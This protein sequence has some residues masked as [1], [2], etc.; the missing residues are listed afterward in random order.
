MFKSSAV[1][2]PGQWAVRLI[3][4]EARAYLRFADT[5]PRVPGF[6]LVNPRA[7][8]R[9]PTAEDLVEEA[10]ARGIEA[11]VLQPKEDAAALARAADADALGIAG[12]DG[13]IASIAEVAIE[14][15]LP[16]VVVPFGTRN[17]FARDIGLDRDDPIAALDAFA[18]DE[19]RQIDVGRAGERLFLNNVSFGLYARLVH[20]RERHRRRRD[21]FARL[22]ALALAA[23]RRHPEPIVVDGNPIKARVV[24]VANNGYELDVFNVGERARLDEGKL[25]AYVAE[26]WWP[27]AW[28]ER[29]GEKFRIG[30]PGGA[31]HAAVDG[32]PAVL[33][34][35]AK[36]RVLPGALRVRLPPQRE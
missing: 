1:S 14:R 35:P 21:A 9:R 12:G 32:E 4:G 7:G 16:L 6:L 23:R 8:N 10:A 26:E 30:T 28:H 18:A 33:E 36:L 25:H 22:R 19:V 31:I 17:H 34:S 3:R 29:V 15:S 13:S 20:R 11:H 2:A 5:L 24:L 27:R